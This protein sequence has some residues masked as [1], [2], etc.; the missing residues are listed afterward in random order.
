MCNRS[1]DEHFWIVASG[2]TTAIQQEPF[3]GQPCQCGAVLWN[4]RPTTG[5]SV[6]RE[7]PPPLIK[8]LGDTPPGKELK[9]IVE[10]L[11]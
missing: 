3:P 2:S 8:P 7:E 5:L 11:C 1:T 4:S 9:W 10:L 6:L